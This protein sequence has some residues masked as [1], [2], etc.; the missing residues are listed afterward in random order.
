MCALFCRQKKGETIPD[1]SYKRSIPKHIWCL[2]FWGETVFAK[3]SCKSKLQIHLNWD[4][5]KY[6]SDVLQLLLDGFRI[7]CMDFLAELSKKKM[8][9]KV[10]KVL[11]CLE[12][13]QST[14]FQVC[15]ELHSGGW[16]S[17]GLCLTILGM[18]GDHPWQLSPDV[19]CKC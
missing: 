1:Q 2:Y 8:P 17:C 14:K 7:E 18:V 3:L 5:N 13:S 9:P 4:P 15:S 10:E 11:N 16:P 12:L 6:T 19:M